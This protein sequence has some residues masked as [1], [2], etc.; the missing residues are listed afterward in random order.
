MLYI[1]ECDQ[2]NMHDENCPIAFAGVEINR[3]KSLNLVSCFLSFEKKPNV[4][5]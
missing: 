3:F 5:V 4:C 2:N 1:F